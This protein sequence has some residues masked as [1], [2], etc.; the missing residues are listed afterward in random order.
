MLMSLAGKT[1]LARKVAVFLVVLAAILV[2][3]S[4]QSDASREDRGVA[5]NPRRSW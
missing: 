1:I 3:C 5:R 4:E 2:G